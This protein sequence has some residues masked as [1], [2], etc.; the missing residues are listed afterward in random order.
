MLALKN[1]VD[2]TSKKYFLDLRNKQYI[3]KKD[4]IKLSKEKLA[5]DQRQVVEKVKQCFCKI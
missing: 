2:S 1:F 3:L 5:Q 4:Q